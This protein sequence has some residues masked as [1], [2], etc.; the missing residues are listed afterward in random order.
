V[1]L[2]AR[3]CI[4]FVKTFTGI[5]LLINNVFP[6]IAKGIAKGNP[7]QLLLKIFFSFSPA[8]TILRRLEE[9]AN[10]PRSFRCSDSA[11]QSGFLKDA[12]SGRLEEAVLQAAK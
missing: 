9:L 4:R 3:E 7:Y 5:I 12:Q 2:I 8:R 6:L 11:S 1:K 10:V